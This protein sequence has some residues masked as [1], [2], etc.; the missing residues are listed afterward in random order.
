MAEKYFYIC[1]GNPVNQYYNLLNFSKLLRN[2]N[3]D[4]F[5]I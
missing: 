4:F 3:C 2:E 5:F 1:K